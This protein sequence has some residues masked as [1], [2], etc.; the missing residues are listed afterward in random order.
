[1]VALIVVAVRVG[2]PRGTLAVA[3]LG[4]VA[5]ATL[6]FRFDG[7]ATTYERMMGTLV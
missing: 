3:A 7:Q 1:M 2:T 5:I 6:N 4:T